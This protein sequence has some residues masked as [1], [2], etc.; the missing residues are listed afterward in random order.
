MIRN[1]SRPI[2]R[3]KLRIAVLS[4]V[5]LASCSVGPE[6]K[7]PAEPVPQAFKEQGPW[8]EAV[9]QDAV[10]K[11]SWWEVFGDPGLNEIEQKARAGNLQLKQA[12]AR[13]EQAR[14]V[15]GIADSYF[16][17]T[18]DLSVNAARAG[19]LLSAIGYL[20]WSGVWDVNASASSPAA[21]IAPD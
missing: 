8:R 20:L 1:P 11:G 13:V 18:I 9:P 21:A 7:R 2:H 6:Y 4:C 17:P 12:Q 3:P 10:A 14:A 5:V 16:Y 15:A 19:V